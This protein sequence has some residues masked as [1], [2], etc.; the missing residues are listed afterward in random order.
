MSIFKKEKVTVI[1]EKILE[2]EEKLKGLTPGT[3]EFDKTL[4]SLN[5]LKESKEKDANNIR[6]SK[7]SKR[8]T[9]ESIGKLVLQAAGIGSGAFVALAVYAFD[10]AG[11]PT[12]SK[13]ANFVQQTVLKDKLK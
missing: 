5:A 6:A 2:T 13:I 12:T 10:A 11:F 9:V 3:D 8:E 4:K 7:K 1:D